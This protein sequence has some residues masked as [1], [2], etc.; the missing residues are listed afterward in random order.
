MPRRGA[1]LSRPGR[2][3][4]QYT[5]ASTPSRTTAAITSHA[6]QLRIDMSGLPFKRAPLAG[7]ARQAS[8]NPQYEQNRQG[9]QHGDDDR[10]EATQ[11]AREEYEHPAALR[12][13]LGLEAHH[14]SHPRH[15]DGPEYQ[16]GHCRAPWGNP[17]QRECRLYGYP[18]SSATRARRFT[19][20]G[21]AVRMGTKMVGWPTMRLWERRL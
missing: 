3:P 11:L 5:N 21:R 4:S 2:A 9:H 14:A 10:A 1:C 13:A 16:I 8:K 12:R 15:A 7:A 17:L 19:N 6:I 20:S 18:V